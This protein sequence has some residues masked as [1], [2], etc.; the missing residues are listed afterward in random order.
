MTDKLILTT[1]QR[2]KQYAALEN[3]IDAVTQEITDHKVMWGEDAIPSRL[4]QRQR[5]EL[6][7]REHKD[8]MD[9]LQS[10]PMVEGEPVARMLHSLKPLVTINSDI[11]RS[12]AEYSENQHSD[13]WREGA[14]LY[15]QPQPLQPESKG[16]FIDLMN[17]HFP[18][19]IE[20]EQPLQPITADDVPDSLC[21][22]T[23][24]DKEKIAEIYNA[25]IKNRSEAG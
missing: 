6:L 1:A 8:A 3:S 4:A 18:N 15:A 22:E 25:V 7:E 16:L 5:L 10:L 20:A 11:A 14:K 2:D 9:M 21:F 23:G 19:G 24:E 12:Y 17:E 13:V